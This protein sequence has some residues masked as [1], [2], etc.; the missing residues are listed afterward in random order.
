MINI[1]NNIRN[2]PPEYRDAKNVMRRLNATMNQDYFDCVNKYITSGPVNGL[3][4][5]NEYIEEMQVISEKYKAIKWLPLDVPKID[6]GDPKEFLEIYNMYRHPIMRVAAD[7]AEPWTKEEHPHKQ[8][9]TYYKESFNGCYLYSNKNIDWPHAWNLGP[10]VGDLPV[11]KRIVEQ[12]H[13][14]FPYYPLVRVHIW[15]SVCYCPPH[16]DN[17]AFW[18]CPTEFRTMLYDENDKP[19]FYVAED[20]SDEPIF[21]DLP[22]DTNSFCWSNGR[23]VHGSDYHGK[24]K[25]LLV[26][27]GIQHTQKSVELFDRSIAKYKDK[28][29]YKLEMNGFI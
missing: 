6:I 15:E 3:D 11:F 20:G 10:Y 29:N 28:L 14:Y 26:V 12:V 22:D 5:A 16:R 2:L 4:P 1:E 8:D 19:T 13:D 9:S 25:L 18:K 27:A 7:V 24:R 21:I 23:M 17:S